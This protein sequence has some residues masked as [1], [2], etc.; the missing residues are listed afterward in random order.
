MRKVK[1]VKV[2]SPILYT[3]PQPHTQALRQ[4]TAILMLLLGGLKGKDHQML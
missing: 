4:A 1:V 2:L 3:S